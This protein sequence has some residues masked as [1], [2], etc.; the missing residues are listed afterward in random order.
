MKETKEQTQIIKDFLQSLVI[1]GGDLSF[2]SN[3]LPSKIVVRNVFKDNSYDQVRIDKEIATDPD[4]IINAIMDDVNYTLV[5]I[6]LPI[7]ALVGFLD[8]D[9]TYL[10]WEFSLDENTLK[11]TDMTITQLFISILPEF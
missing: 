11:S 10:I 8:N 5:Y 2:V 7:K 3:V 9:K 6:P 1:G 4:E